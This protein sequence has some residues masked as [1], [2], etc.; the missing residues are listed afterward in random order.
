MRG[1]EPGPA[2]WAEEGTRFA[3]APIDGS[4]VGLHAKTLLDRISNYP[5]ATQV[6][7]SGAAFFRIEGNLVRATVG[8]RVAFEPVVYTSPAEWK[9]KL[10]DLTIDESGTWWAAGHASNDSLIG[11]IFSSQDGTRWQQVPGKIEG[12]VVHLVRWN[13]KLHALH[14]KHLSVVTPDGVT[15]IA[16]MKDHINHAIFTESAIVAFGDA[17][18]GVLAANAKRSKYAALP[19]GHG[20]LHAAAIDGGFVAGDHKGLWSSPDGL[21]WQPVPS[22]TGAVAAI[23]P[24]AAG[25]IVVSTQS[26]VYVVR[27]S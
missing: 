2:W 11:Q 17:F 26:E 22:F 7:A 10:E 4:A 21:A 13:G 19:S 9:F 27:A 16:S 5:W 8:P 14:Y 20:K 6:T 25:A 23:V 3:E 12:S 18:I 24:S 15:K 1:P